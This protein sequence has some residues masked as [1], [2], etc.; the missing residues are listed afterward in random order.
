MGRDDNKPTGLSGATGALKAWLG[1]M[2]E[3]SHVPMSSDAPPGVNYV[4][5]NEATGLLSAENCAGARYIPFI[6]GTEPTTT[7]GTCGSTNEV[8]QWFQQLF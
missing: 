5:V 8:M 1:F 3:T 6:E 7:D 2:A 4:W